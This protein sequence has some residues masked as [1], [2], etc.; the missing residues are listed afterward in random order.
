M[1][2]SSDIIYLFN[3]AQESYAPTVGPPTDNNMV[4]FHEAILS[5]L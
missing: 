1:L 3:T 2:T 4:R 5:I